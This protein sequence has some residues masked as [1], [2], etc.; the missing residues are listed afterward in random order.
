MLKVIL[1]RAQCGMAGFESP[2]AEYKQVGL[3]LS[4][5]LIQHPEATYACYAEG[6]SMIGDGIFSGD[7]LIVSREVKVNNGDI[8]V[9]NLNGDFVCKK[10]DTRRQRL[11]SSSK[12][13]STYQLREGEDFQVEGVVISSVRLHREFTKAI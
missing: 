3:N 11:I 12:E 1:P 10:I 6:D 7:L 2:A 9:A 8:I 4:E 5:L 13:F